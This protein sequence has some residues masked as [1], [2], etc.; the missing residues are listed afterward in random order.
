MKLD[1]HH[2]NM[3]NNEGLRANLRYAVARRE[4]ARSTLTRKKK[5]SLL[6]TVGNILHGQL[7]VQDGTKTVWEFPDNTVAIFKEK[8]NVQTNP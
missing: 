5:R 2:M 3:L 4:I 1:Q 7:V 8:P 6:L